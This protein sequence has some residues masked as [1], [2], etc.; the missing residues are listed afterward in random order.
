MAT[1]I[2]S[3]LR[4]ATRKHSDKYNILSFPTHERFQSGLSLTGHNFYLFQ[5]ENIKGWNPI[6]APLPA[7]HTLLNPS[8]GIHQIPVDL[9]LDCILSQNK[10]GQFPVAAQLAR[11]LHLPLISLEHT[12]PV[13]DWD[14]NRLK[15]I[16]SMQGNINIFISEYSGKAWGWD[17]GTY[18]VIHHGIDTEVFSP[19]P[20]GPKQPHVLSIVNDFANR[21]WCCGFNL[22]RYVTKDLPVKLLGDTP[23]LSKPAKDTAELVAS[24]R[25]TQVF[26][27][28]SLIS[29]I[30]TVVLEAMSCGCAVVSTDTCM[31]PDIIKHG[32]NGLLGSSPDDLRSCVNMLLEDEGLARHLGD[33]ARRTIVERFNM[34]KFVRAWD[35]VFTR[36]STMPFTGV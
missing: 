19:G 28:T 32:E 14:D 9:D 16:R 15:Y 18:E 35:D 20:Y 3:I 5:G 10:F 6:Y 31:I 2:G 13:P 21:D 12:L 11:A 7:N 27:N 25:Q 8:L 24:Y 1:L 30:P 26:L 17:E 4:Q 23:G 29:P 36:A 22:W 33:N 34:D